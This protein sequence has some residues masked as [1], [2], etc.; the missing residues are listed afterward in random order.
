MSG[1]YKLVIQNKQKEILQESGLMQYSFK[2]DVLPVFQDIFKTSTNLVRAT[3]ISVGATLEYQIIS[4]NVKGFASLANI[5]KKFQE[6]IEEADKLY[7]EA[8]PESVR[9]DVETLFG[10]TNPAMFMGR[11][12][13]ES[14]NT[15]NMDSYIPF[16]WFT[17]YL[18]SKDFFTTDVKKFGELFGAF[19]FNNIIWFKGWIHK[20]LII[21]NFNFFKDNVHL[22]SK[23][24]IESLKG[25]KTVNDLAAKSNKVLYFLRAFK[26]Y[27]SLVSPV[28]EFYDF[29]EKWQPGMLQMY[30][31]ITVYEHEVAKLKEMS[32]SDPGYSAQ[33][34]KVEEVRIK[35]D[36]LLR[37]FG[38]DMNLAA[39][40]ILK[41]EMEYIPNI[42]K[43]FSGEEFYDQVIVPTVSAE[44][45]KLY[46]S[47][48]FFL[49]GYLNAPI[50][51]LNKGIDALNILIPGDFDIP[52][53]PTFPTDPTPPSDNDN[54]NNR[55]NNNLNNNG[56]ENNNNNRGNNLDN[57]D[58]PMESYVLKI[59]DQTK[60]LFEKNLNLNAT[61]VNRPE[62]ATI[63][64][65]QS[66]LQTVSDE[67][68]N[69]LREL[70]L[71]KY[72]PNGAEEI[73]I[74][75]LLSDTKISKA[76]K[77][78][79]EL[80]KITN[81]LKNKSYEVKKET[82][83]KM[84]SLS[85]KYFDNIQTELSNSLNDLK[86]DQTD[87]SKKVNAE[88][89]K[90]YKFELTPQGFAKKLSYDFELLCN[91]NTIYV[92]SYL[93][94]IQF[95]IE[96]NQIIY[97]FLKNHDM[98]ETRLLI[99]NLRNNVNKKLF[100]DD[101]LVKKFE[102]MNKEISNLFGETSRTFEIFMQA[103]SNLQKAVE[104][105]KKNI[106]SFCNNY[107]SVINDFEKLTEIDVLNKLNDMITEFDLTLQVNMEEIYNNFLP[108]LKKLK[109][110]F[111]INLR[112]KKDSLKQEFDQILIRMDLQSFDKIYT[113]N[114]VKFDE[115]YNECIKYI[116]L[117][118][119]GSK[120]YSNLTELKD[121]Q[122]VYQEKINQIASKQI[123]KTENETQ[124]IIPRDEN[125]TKT[126]KSDKATLKINTNQI[127]PI[128]VNTN[129]EEE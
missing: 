54:N 93:I 5:N 50:D 16:W 113:E 12:L 40:T 48:L 88:F 108:S 63:N 38:K 114:K 32:E 52:N 31:N 106:F 122:K 4:Q 127:N 30:E 65:E 91:I 66:E 102:S 67:D 58:Q 37:Q 110:N 82:F 120:L 64:K 41:H 123:T 56:S 51:K 24:N 71:N 39:G 117:S 98:A 101:K 10:L 13:L 21:S 25:I 126:K 78:W 79:L 80:T 53:I 76:S 18:L 35:R 89:N 28:V 119:E 69:E 125:T 29:C 42:I 15:K 57:R 84:L 49:G 96:K 128:S 1:Y 36:K 97:K 55:G 74:R 33:K 11:R 62:I 103:Q 111:N 105:N 45:R 34:Q 118:K 20:K 121:L 115:R 87:V 68:L 19:K 129:E 3:V 85:L 72:S 9:G 99:N 116:G 107:M 43:I 44:T 47:A 26:A 6:K 8:I 17:K 124:K 83:F 7:K 77:Q 23:S 92:G 86:N 60:F 109:D 75:N 73:I 2:K 81:Q 46:Y 22:L 70:G 100:I 95:I 104:E 90:K 61:N 27:E 112:N 14:V 59:T 94:N